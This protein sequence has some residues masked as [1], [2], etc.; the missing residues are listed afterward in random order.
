M[1][2][3]E[4]FKRIAQIETEAKELRK[5][6]DSSVTCATDLK[7]TEDVCKVLG[8]GLHHF[9]AC[10]IYDQLKYIIKAAN[11]LD[12]D[13]KVWIADFNNSDQYKYYPYAEKVGSGLRFGCCRGRSVSSY[14]FS[15]SFFFKESKT[16]E[17]IFNTFIKQYSEYY[18][19]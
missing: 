8:I 9:T 18:E 1:N 10:N 4:A 7:T 15:K 11:M 3:Q 5:I 12:N 17:Y 16:C 6:I 19:Q 14:G 2:K 13:G